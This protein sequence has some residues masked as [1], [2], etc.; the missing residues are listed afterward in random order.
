MGDF[1]KKISYR[2]ILRKKLLQGNN[3]QKNPTVKKIYFTAYNDML[4]RKKSLHRCMSGQ[5]SISRGL[6]EKILHNQN[7]PYPFS[8]VKWS[9]PNLNSKN[10]LIIN[11]Q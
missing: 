10:E 9:V 11:K 3:W 7:H 1:S 4:G 6:G 2:L 5:N 8:K